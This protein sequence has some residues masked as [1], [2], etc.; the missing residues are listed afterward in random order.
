MRVRHASWF[1]GIRFDFESIEELYTIRDLSAAPRPLGKA[2][3]AFE[4]ANH[5]TRLYELGQN[6]F[7]TQTTKHKKTYRASERGMSFAIREPN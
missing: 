3:I 7:D 5:P 2:P 1:T 6:Q 4:S